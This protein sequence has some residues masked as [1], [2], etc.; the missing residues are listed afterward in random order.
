MI[1]K[2]LSLIICL[3]SGIIFLFLPAKHWTAIN[4]RRL[5]EIGFAVGLFCYLFSK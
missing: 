4:F 3:V 5:A 1:T 2:D